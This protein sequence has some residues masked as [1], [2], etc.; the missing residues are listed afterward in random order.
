MRIFHLNHTSKLNPLSRGYDTRSIWGKVCLWISPSDSHYNGVI[1]SAMA[2]K[3]TSL[4]IAYSGHRPKK[5]SKLCVTGLCEGNSPGIGE[6][7]AQRAN[8]AENVSIWW[9]HHGISFPIWLDLNCHVVS[10]YV[11]SL[12]CSACI[13][14]YLIC[15]RMHM[16]CRYFH[17]SIFLL[18][19]LLYIWPYVRRFIAIHFTVTQHVS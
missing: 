4:T 6:F 18:I 2:S 14:M 16:T 11:Q 3:I 15:T 19:A 12:I 7:P 1:M 10:R 13:Y 8:N 5:T 9:R 17:S